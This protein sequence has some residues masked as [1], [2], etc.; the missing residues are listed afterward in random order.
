MKQYDV[1]ELV[2]KVDYCQLRYTSE[3]N[4]SFFENVDAAKDI[5]P[6][7]NISLLP[8]AFEWGCELINLQQPLWKPGTRSGLPIG[9]WN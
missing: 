3:V 4:F 6:F 5:V 7:E 9:Y 1:I 8:F 2:T